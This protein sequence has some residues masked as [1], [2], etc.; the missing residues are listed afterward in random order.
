MTWR[1]IQVKPGLADTAR[2][3]INTRFELSV[4]E[5][6]FEPSVLEL[7]GILQRGEQYLAGSTVRLHPHAAVVVPVGWELSSR[8]VEPGRYYILLAT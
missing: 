6:R 5:S 2:H 3:V 4:V 8:A 7:D 1:A